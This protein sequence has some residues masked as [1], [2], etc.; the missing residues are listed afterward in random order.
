MRER[1]NTQKVFLYNPD[2][3]RTNGTSFHRWK[4]VIKL[5]L[6]EIR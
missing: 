3:K 1:R 5:D 6:K 2:R 4:V